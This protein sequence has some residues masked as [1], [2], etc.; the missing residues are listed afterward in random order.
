LVFTSFLLLTACTTDSGGGTSD[1]T[2]QASTGTT[3]T[4]GDSSTSPAESTGGATTIQPGTDST[5]TAAS[6]S[7]TP[8]TETGTTAA[9][10]TASS[11]T[12]EAVAFTLT[13]PDFVEGGGLPHTAHINGGNVSPALDWVGAPAGTMSYA[14]FFHD[15]TIDFNHSAIWNIGAD[16]DG[17]PEGVDHDAMPG[18][19]P[20]AVQCENWA[21]SIGYGGPGSQANFYEF[22]LYAIDVDSLDAEIDENSTLDEVFTALEAHSLGTTTL[23][24]QSTGP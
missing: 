16:L 23:T 2:G 6:E 13:S 21:G 22:V 5:T 18:N 20:G 17:L 8:A 12:T 9:D 19:V 14:V 10:D 24:G 3:Q 7:G 1:T 15:I 11:G 4:A